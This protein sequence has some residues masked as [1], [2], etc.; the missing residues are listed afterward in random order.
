MEL[1]DCDGDSFE[2]GLYQCAN[3]F[4]KKKEAEKTVFVILADLVLL[5]FVQSWWGFSVFCISNL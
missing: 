3:G 2:M 1:Y 5:F 4:F